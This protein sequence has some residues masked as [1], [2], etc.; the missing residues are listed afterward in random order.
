MLDLQ[1]LP[2]NGAVCD[3][4]MLEMTSFSGRHLNKDS[5]LNAPGAG[6]S[7]SSPSIC[8]QVD[9]LYASMCFGCVVMCQKRVI[10]FC[11]II[12]KMTESSYFGNI[13]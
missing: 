12:Y 10:Y 1:G 6:L 3:D 7:D 4:V 5:A 9:G 13:C 2:S 11:I 8:S